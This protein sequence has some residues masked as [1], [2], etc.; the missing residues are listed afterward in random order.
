MN[1]CYGDPGGPLY[2]RES[3]TLVGMLSG[4]EAGC[5]IFDSSS[6]Y[7]RVS[8]AKDWIITTVCFN[9]TVDSELCRIPPTKKPSDT[10]PIIK[11]SR[12]NTPPTKKPRDAIV[13]TKKQKDA[14]IPTK[15]PR[16]MSSPKIIFN[17]DSNNGTH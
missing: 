7:A 16:N 6:A 13:S 4:G 11:K 15:K 10:A 3:Q 9:G 14:I 2:E 1:T 17:N 5:N 8:L 12:G